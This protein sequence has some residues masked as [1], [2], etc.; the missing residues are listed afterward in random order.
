[1][2]CQSSKDGGSAKKKGKSHAAKMIKFD[3]TGCHS[4]DDF[5]SNVRKILKEFADLL[6]PLEEAENHFL[7]LTGFWRYHKASKSFRCFLT[8]NSYQTLHARH[9]PLSRFSC[10]RKSIH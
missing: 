9:G 7:D 5:L 6:E 4:W 1:M 8:S 2:G 3:D 10:R